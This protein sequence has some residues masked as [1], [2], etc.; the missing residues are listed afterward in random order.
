LGGAYRTVFRL[1]R[2]WQKLIGR[3][4][5]DLIPDYWIIR[6][7]LKQ[8]TGFTSNIDMTKLDRKN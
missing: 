7:H 2:Q 3:G 8:Q 5:V 1:K 4:R 6:K